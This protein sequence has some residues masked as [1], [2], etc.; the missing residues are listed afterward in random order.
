MF[1]Q[2]VHFQ[3]TKEIRK[4]LEFLKRS[5][6]NHYTIILFDDNHFVGIDKMLLE[7]TLVMQVSK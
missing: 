3:K 1:L 2:Y 5:I 7:I 6:C 4:R